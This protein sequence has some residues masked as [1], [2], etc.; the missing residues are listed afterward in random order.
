[1]TPA[2]VTRFVAQAGTWHGASCLENAD[3]NGQPAFQCRVEGTGG[4][5]EKLS[6]V[7]T[8]DGAIRQ[9]TPLAP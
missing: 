9:T 1:M 7:V 5:L 4:G 3:V 8:V 6:I 2:D